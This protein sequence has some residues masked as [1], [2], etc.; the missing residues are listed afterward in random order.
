MGYAEV[1]LCYP[2][3]YLKKDGGI[4]AKVPPKEHTCLRMNIPPIPK[5]N[6]DNKKQK[7]D[8]NFKIENIK[9]I[10]HQTPRRPKP[11]YAD[12]KNGDFH[13]LEKSGLMPIYIY[14]PK[15]GKLPSYLIK[16]IRD[17]AIQQEM[18]EDD[19]ARKQPLCRY[20]TQEERAELLGVF[21]TIYKL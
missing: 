13:D 7:K 21:I 15:F 6:S 16:R 9:K 19:A 8:I 12:T 4:R 1:R 17:A 11:R 14:Q 5:R 3:N 18:R 20:I 2:D 10:I